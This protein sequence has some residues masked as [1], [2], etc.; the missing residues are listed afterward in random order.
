[1]AAY[2]TNLPDALRRDWL[3]STKV[4]KADLP[5]EVSGKAKIK[6][7]KAVA[8]MRHRTGEARGAHLWATTAETEHPRTMA[9]KASWR[10]HQPSIPVPNGF[11]K[12][13]LPNGFS[14]QQHTNLPPA[15]RASTQFPREGSNEAH[16]LR[17]FYPDIKT[18][19]VFY[20]REEPR[21]VSLFRFRAC[22]G[23]LLLFNIISNVV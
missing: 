12:P 15:L 9:E 13:S 4:L 14:N 16:I 7:M 5:F 8:D 23:L 11:T 6:G 17:G 20:E 18:K 2:G 1:M 3:A 22:R 19:P 21:Y 10:L